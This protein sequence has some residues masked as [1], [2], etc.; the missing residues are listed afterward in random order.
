MAKTI[1]LIRHGHHPLL[2]RYLCGR[3]PGVSLDLLG[4]RQMAHCAELMHPRPDIVRSSPQLRARQSA[5]VLGGAL[6]LR[7]EVASEVD[8]LDY[9]EWTGQQFADLQSDPAWLRWNTQRSRN[10]P[11]GGESMGALQTRVVAYLDRLRNDPAGTIALVSHAEPI[12]AALLHYKGLS[13]DEFLSIKVEP[14]SIST[15]SLEEDRVQVGHSNDGV[16]A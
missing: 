1:H 15:L 10:R 13:L 7:V 16:A 8:E 4:R 12:R 2:G 6:G 5:N 9:G 14:A 3:Q 11:P